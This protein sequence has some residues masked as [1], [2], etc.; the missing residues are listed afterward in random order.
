MPLF[1]KKI[2]LEKKRTVCTTPQDFNRHA[3]ILI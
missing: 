3:E 2:N 1:K